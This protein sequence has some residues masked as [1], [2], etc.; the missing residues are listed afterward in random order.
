MKNFIADGETMLITAGADLSAG[1]VH[2]M[3]GGIGVA[4][5]DIANGAV[6]AVRVR[7]AFRLPKA[8]GTAWTAGD[9][10]YWDATPGELT[11]TSTSN[12]PA[13]IAYADA[14][15]SDAVGVCVLNVGAYLGT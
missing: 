8:T 7:G 1:D 9:V 12:T 2:A 6:G 4:I 14:G 10:L 5:E 13:G 15:S 3:A 11:K